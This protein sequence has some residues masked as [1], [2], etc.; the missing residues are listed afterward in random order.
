MVAGWI[1]VAVIALI[2]VV[3]LFKSQDLV[4]VLGLIRKNIFYVFL[5]AMLL[6]FAFS[7]THI[8]NKYDVDY[9]SF[10]GITQAGKIYFLWMK[11]F[12]GNLGGVTGYAV[13][14]DWWLDNLN[15]TKKG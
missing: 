4:G 3:F 1:I 12:F 10:D 14:Q 7:L 2:V 11:S 6:F 8:H 13:E 9:T 5:I 15:V